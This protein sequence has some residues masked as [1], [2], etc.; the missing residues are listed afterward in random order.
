MQAI[1]ET[2]LKASLTPQMRGLVKTIIESAAALKQLMPDEE[3]EHGFE[4]HWGI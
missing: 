3:F 2:E 4:F 1:A